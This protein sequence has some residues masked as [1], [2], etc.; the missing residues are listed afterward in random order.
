MFE[1]EISR[2]KVVTALRQAKDSHDEHDHWFFACFWRGL[3]HEHRSFDTYPANELSLTA[4]FF[5]NLIRYHLIEFVPLDIAVGYVLDGLR[6][7][8]DS[9]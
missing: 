3:F 6:N 7:P 8:P 9:N 4:S 2:D 1:R 5:G